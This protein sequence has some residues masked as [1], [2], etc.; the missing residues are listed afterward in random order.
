MEQH[1]QSNQE[2][3]QLSHMVQKQQASGSQRTHDSGDLLNK[4]SRGSRK[5]G[6]REH[7]TMGT[8]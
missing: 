5:V 7:R 3:G 8:C 1:R 6:L 2:V 4:W